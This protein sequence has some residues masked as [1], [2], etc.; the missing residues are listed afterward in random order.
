M[1]V[2]RSMS[3]S[4]SSTGQRDHSDARSRRTI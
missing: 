1:S 4:R 3:V 2:A